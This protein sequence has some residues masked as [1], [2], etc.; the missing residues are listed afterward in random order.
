MPCDRCRELATT[1][2]I[3]VPDD[4]RKAIRIGRAAVTDGTLRELPGT[5]L[6]TAEPFSAVSADGPWDDVVSYQ[7]ACAHCGQRFHLWAD[8]YHGSG[9][10]TSE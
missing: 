2:H 8:T 7:F 4:L 9:A 5:P 3:G 1:F 10:W 6:V